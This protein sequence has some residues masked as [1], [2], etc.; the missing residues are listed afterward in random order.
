MPRGTDNCDLLPM[1]PPCLSIT[2]QQQEGPSLAHFQLIKRAVPLHFVEEHEIVHAQYAREKAK[3][4]ALQQQALAHK[5]QVVIEMWK[6]CNH[7][8]SSQLV[9]KVKT[10]LL[11]ARIPIQS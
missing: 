8:T 2:A 6:V 5:Q 11:R 3:S 4:S 7:G 1:S 9:L 10:I